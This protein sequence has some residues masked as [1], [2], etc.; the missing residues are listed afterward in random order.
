MNTCNKAPK[1]WK[2]TRDED[3]E[4]PCAA[5]KIPWWKQVLSSLGNAIGEAKFGD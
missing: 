3:H 5:V 1:G 4:G 2:C